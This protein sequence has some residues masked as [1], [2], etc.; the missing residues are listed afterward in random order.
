MTLFFEG[1]LE[2]L[3]QVHASFM[4]RVPNLRDSSQQIIVRINFFS[5]M[6]YAK[7]SAADFH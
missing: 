2:D 4:Y 7:C 3:I 6:C 1:N 5:I